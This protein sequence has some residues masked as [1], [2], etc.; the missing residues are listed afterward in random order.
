MGERAETIGRHRIYFGAN[1]QFFGFSTLDGIDLKHMPAEFKHLE[2]P[3][4]GQLPI[5]QQ[6][7]ISTSNRVDLKLHQVTLFGTYGLTNKL[8]VSVAIPILDVRM[9]VTST[10]HIIRIAPCELAGDC[11][12]RCQ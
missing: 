11:N 8:D 1:Y 5:F 7:Y 9:G 2:F 6:D 10:A 3:I 12:D 4:N